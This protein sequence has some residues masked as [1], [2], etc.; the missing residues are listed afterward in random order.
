M[1]IETVKGQFIDKQLVLENQIKG[2]ITCFAMADDG[3]V[4]VTYQRNE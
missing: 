2:R 4:F 1:I 3:S